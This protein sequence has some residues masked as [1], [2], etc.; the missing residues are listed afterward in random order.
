MGPPSVERM[1]GRGERRH[2]GSDDQTRLAGRHLYARLD[3]DQ[4]LEQDFNSLDAQREASERPTSRARHT[5]AG[6]WFGSVTMTAASPGARWIGR[7][8]RSCS[9]TCRRNGSM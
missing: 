9:L 2:E 6:D 3:T 4:G 5:R 7:P 1:A 8:Y